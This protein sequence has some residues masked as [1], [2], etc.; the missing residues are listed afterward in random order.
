MKL[1]LRLL[2]ILLDLK[3]TFLTGDIHLNTVDRLIPMRSKDAS[4][5]RD[6]GSLAIPCICHFL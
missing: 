2:Q 4:N 3:D 6:K 5:L 1:P